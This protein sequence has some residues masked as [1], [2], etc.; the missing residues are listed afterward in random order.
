MASVGSH[1][2]VLPESKPS[3]YSSGNP[4]SVLAGGDDFSPPDVCGVR[5]NDRTTQVAT[6]GSNRLGIVISNWQTRM[7]RDLGDEGVVVLGE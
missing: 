6:A 1:W 2:S 3:E 4:F 7:Q 5:A